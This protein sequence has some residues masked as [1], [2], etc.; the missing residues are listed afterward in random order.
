L[1]YIAIWGGGRGTGEARIYYNIIVELLYTY[2]YVSRPLN[3]LVI[4]TCWINGVTH[5]GARNK[6]KQKKKQK[7]N[8]KTN[9]F[10]C[11]IRGKIVSVF[12][13]TAKLFNRGFDYT[14]IDKW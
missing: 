10:L 3:V 2:I 13:D 14:S 11:P 12:W 5:N 8:C 4:Y 6:T 9:D 7:K 1:K